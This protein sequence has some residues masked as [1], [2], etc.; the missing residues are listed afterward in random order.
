VV[1]GK[2]KIA[3]VAVVVDN[4]V[5]VVDGTALKDLVP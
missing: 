2:L 3:R 4:L 5:L 1:I